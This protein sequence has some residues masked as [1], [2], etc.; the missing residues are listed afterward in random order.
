MRRK[1]TAIEAEILRVAADIFSERGYQA[2]TLDDIAAAAHIS[3]ATFYTYFPSKAELLR[4]MYRQ[5]TSTT[6]AAI[7][8]IAAEAL[9]VP[10]KLR[11][12]IRYQIA[13][14]TAHKPL[15]QVFFA[16][17]FNLPPEMSRSVTQAN[18][19]FSRVIEQVVEEGVRTGALIPLNPKRFTYA[20]IGMCNWTP[21]W[22]RPGG[23]WTADAIADEFIRILESGYLQQKTEPGDQVLVREI[24]ALRQ[25]IAQLKLMIPTAA[26]PI[27]APRRRA[28]VSRKR[29]RA[30]TH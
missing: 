5:V 28:A 21:R 16:E 25:E 6:Q 17:V 29:R 10:E 23:E 24:R 12:I 9:P 2:T 22:Y 14:L 7:E 26:T 8:R 11:R 30:T 4:R 13:Y 19:A 15:V 3:R 1:H 18:R 27:P 20:L